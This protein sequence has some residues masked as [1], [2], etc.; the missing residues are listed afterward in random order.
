MN[1]RSIILPEAL[2][3]IQSQDASILTLLSQLEG[4][5]RG[6]S[7]SLETMVEQ[8]ESSHR[9]YIMGLE[10]STDATNQG[11]YAEV[12]VTGV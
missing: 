9:K 11:R 1:F 10:V 6:N 2:K 8:L 5:V 3:L 4:M 12:G 7:V